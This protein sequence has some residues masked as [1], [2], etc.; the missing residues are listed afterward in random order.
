M[1]STNFSITNWTPGKPDAALV[2]FEFKA[3][4]DF[5]IPPL[6]AGAAT[7]VGTNPT[8]SAEYN[9]NK[10]GS[11]IG[12]VTVATDGTVALAGAGASF[13]AASAD[14]FQLVAPVSQDATLADVS[15]NL[16]A[17]R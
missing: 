10:N 5:N 13:S 1:A 2:L 7:T 11:S 17:T 3:T 15:I 14:V 12:T 9:V 16:L 8:A 6:L 4:F